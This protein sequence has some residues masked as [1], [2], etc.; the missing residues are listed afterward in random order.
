MKGA[1]TGDVIQFNAHSLT[2]NLPKRRQLIQGGPKK[3]IGG[4]M[5]DYT[6]QQKKCQSLKVSYFPNFGALIPNLTIIFKFME[7]IL[8]CCQFRVFLVENY[9]FENISKF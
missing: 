6:C 5:L 7:P 2:L 9:I 1:S 3:T 4:K 8:Q